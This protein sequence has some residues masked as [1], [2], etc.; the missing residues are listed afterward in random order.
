MVLTIIVLLAWCA[1]G[2][3]LAC[4]IDNRMSGGG[5]D[6]LPKDKLLPFVVLLGPVV[7]L[8]ALIGLADGAI[9]KLVKWLETK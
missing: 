6:N 7:W 5:L 4:A 2:F 8:I 1:G 3:F 9:D